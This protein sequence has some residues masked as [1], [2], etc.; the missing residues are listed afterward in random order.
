MEARDERRLLKLQAQLAAGKLLIVDELGHVVALAD[1]RGASLRNIQPASR[2]RLD[3]R[4]VE[5]SLFRR[6]HRGRFS[7]D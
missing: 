5:S 3:H 2:T 7:G 4:H 1:R 6:D